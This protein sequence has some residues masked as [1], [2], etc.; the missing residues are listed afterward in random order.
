MRSTTFARIGISLAATVALGL[1]PALAGEVQAAGGGTVVAARKSAD[2]PQPT[3][4]YRAVGAQHRGGH[5]RHC[6][7]VEPWTGMVHRCSGQFKRS[8]H[9][10]LIWG[11][12][13]APEFEPTLT[14]FGRAGT[15]FVYVGNTPVDWVEMPATGDFG[16]IVT[17]SST[18]GGGYVK[19]TQRIALYDTRGRLV[20]WD[21]ITLDW[22]W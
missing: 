18:Y 15:F 14:P 4:A 16:G 6:R 12:I 3:T 1:S 20:A 19:G 22:D 21:W 9:A 5:S 13:W 10:D 7:P 11:G 8:N 2:K 17:L